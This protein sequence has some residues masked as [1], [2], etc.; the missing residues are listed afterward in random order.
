MKLETKAFEKV[1]RV[2]LFFREQIIYVNV[3]VCL[4]VL[5]G[6]LSPTPISRPDVQV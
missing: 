4:A 2:I 5:F 6:N 3:F 1:G